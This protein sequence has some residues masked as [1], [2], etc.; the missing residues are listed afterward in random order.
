MRQSA[1]R[2]RADHTACEKENWSKQHLRMLKK[3]NGHGEVKL[4]LPTLN[5][6]TIKAASIEDGTNSHPSSRRLM[7]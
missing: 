1:Y 5:P 6:A 2:H 3:V 4:R 7:T